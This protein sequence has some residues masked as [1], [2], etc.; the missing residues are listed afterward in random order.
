MAGIILNNCVRLLQSQ[1]TVINTVVVLHYSRVFG[2]TDNLKL[3][4]GKSRKS[5]HTVKCLS[6]LLNVIP[7][8][9]GGGGLCFSK[10]E[11]M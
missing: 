1:R 7:F 4:F 11:F 3:Q 6:R 8:S 5:V 9:W 10:A 2:K